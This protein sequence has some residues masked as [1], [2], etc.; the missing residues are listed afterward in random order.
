MHRILT[1]LISISIAAWAAQPPAPDRVG[2]AHAPEFV[3]KAV[4]LSPGT[5]ALEQRLLP[6]MPR[7]SGVAILVT[8]AECGQG[9]MGIAAFR[10]LEHRLRASGIAFRV[11]VKSAPT[12][13]RQYARLFL[14]P[15]A[16]IGDPGGESLSPLDIRVV[17]TLV[18]LNR[19]GVVVSHH[20]PLST[21]AE[22]APAIARRASASALARDVFEGHQTVGIHLD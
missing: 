7:D 11:V 14:H 1:A 22:D 10:E 20:A 8:T 6:L 2:E 16:V 4:R 18:V 17:P 19:A 5:T 21:R 3:G 13:S 9:R 15:E 12:P